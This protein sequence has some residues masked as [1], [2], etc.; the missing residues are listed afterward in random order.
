MTSWDLVCKYNAIVIEL[1]QT[2]TFLFNLSIFFCSFFRPFIHASASV[3]V[4]SFTWWMDRQPLQSVRPSIHPSHP[5]IHPSI[6][7]VCLSIH[8]LRL[9]IHLSIHPFTPSVYPSIYSVC[10]S[11]PSTHPIHI[12]I[13]PLIH[14]LRP[15]IHSSI[16]PSIHLLRLPIVINNLMAHLIPTT[17]K[18]TMIPLKILLKQLHHL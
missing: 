10:P 6:Y 7:P 4:H 16:H 8:L 17:T 15:S 13:Y 18:W 1:K 14:L 11:T 5:F 2:T 3:S 12:S 9:S